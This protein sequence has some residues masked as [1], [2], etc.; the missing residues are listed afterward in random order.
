MRRNPGRLNR[1][2]DG[3]H[4]LVIPCEKGWRNVVTGARVEIRPAHWLAWSPGKDEPASFRDP[5]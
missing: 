4:P 5:T 1:D 2:K 3:V